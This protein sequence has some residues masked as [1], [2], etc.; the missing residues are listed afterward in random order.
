MNKH[1]GNG[2][3][4]FH[5]GEL[6][7]RLIIIVIVNLLSA[8]ICY[9]WINI[10]INYLLLLNPGMS[11]VYIDPSELVMV[12]FKLSLIIGMLFA[13]P[14]TIYQIWAFMAKGLYKKE[15]ITIIISLFFGIFCFVLGAIF[16]Y[17]I[18]IPMTLDF[19]MRM[20]IPEVT[21]MIS[22]QSFMDFVNLMLISFGLCAEIP[23]VTFLLT[24][25]NVLKP[26]M[27]YRYHKVF[28]VII[29]VIAAVI[30]PP[31]VISQV[32]LAI[33]MVSLLELSIF[34]SWVVYRKKQK[35]AE[36]KKLNLS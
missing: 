5:L 33:P 34:I 9:Q 11:F 27:L 24:S 26:Q 15:K 23:V 16:S 30:T 12:Y 32:I 7:K 21:A 31:D 4:V 28:V 2:D 29:F 19:F 6:R 35:N 8:I 14:I 10:L 1:K 13:S 3:L 36:E 20:S 25:L 22:I 18:A 17:F